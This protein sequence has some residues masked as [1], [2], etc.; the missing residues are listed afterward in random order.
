[1]TSQKAVSFLSRI[2]CAFS[3]VL[4]S[5]SYFAPSAIA[6]FTPPAD[7]RRA[8]GHRTTTGT[9]QGSCVDA[10][11]TDFTL[12]GPYVEV[13][14]TTS[15]R[16]EF[17]WHLPA[18]DIN[19]TVEFRLRAPNEQGIPV[20]IYTDT[21]DYKPGFNKYS[22]PP[23]EAPLSRNVEYR[24]Q[25]V[26]VCD[27]NALS[28]SLNRELF[29]EVV[30]ASPTLQRALE[31]AT[32]EADRA[33]AYGEA[34]YWYDAIALVADASTPQAKTTRQTLLKDLVSAEPDVIDTD[35]SNV[36]NTA[37]T[38]ADVAAF[39]EDVMAIVEFVDR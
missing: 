8:S 3:A 2:T 15:T 37:V 4:L 22:L 23:T 26:I 32:T 17:V 24:W 31:S 18:S 16:P 6:G 12:L 19:Y 28:R 27:P 9:R 20:P 35:E 30:P 5:T 29:F 21:L 1:M 39:K 25:I 11:Q 33:N 13:G 34:G 10:S 7:G 38:A 36:M 14:Q